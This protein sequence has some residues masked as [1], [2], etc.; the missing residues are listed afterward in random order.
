MNL[1]I[2]D[3]NGPGKYDISSSMVHPNKKSVVDWSK[4]KQKRF[5]YKS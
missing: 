5:N 3:V 4:Y 1:N 2:R